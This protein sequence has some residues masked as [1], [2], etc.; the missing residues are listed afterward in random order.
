LPNFTTQEIDDFRSGSFIANCNKNYQIL[1]NSDLIT[2]DIANQDMKLISP[3]SVASG[4][5]YTD[6]VKLLVEVVLM[7]IRLW[8]M[9]LRHYI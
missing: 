8:M 2:I 1:E 4:K 7:L 9:E 6:L 5:G 3:L